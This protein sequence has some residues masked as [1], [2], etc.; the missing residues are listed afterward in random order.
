M[1][2]ARE[3]PEDIKQAAEQCAGEI[4]A[5]VTDRRGWRQAWDGFEE[6]VRAEI[7]DAHYTIIAEALL[8]ERD[9]QT[10]EIEALRAQ[11]KQE[12]EDN[13]EMLL[14]AHLDGATRNREAHANEVK[15]L[16]A[17]TAWRPI[18][19]APRDGTHILAR[20][21]RERILDMDG[22]MMPKF[23]EIREIWYQPFTMFGVSVP[24]H[25]GDPF[26]G[27]DIASTHMGDDVPTE[28]MPLPSAPKEP[29]P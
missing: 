11:L 1:S 5:D 14:I 6:D 20:L 17:A 12:Q 26:D 21:T 3:M 18:E 10:A 19:T 24:W 8:A 28:W 4:L 23:S 16:K 2:E 13:S 29:T 15:A 25:A 22:R 7:V 27:D 9:R